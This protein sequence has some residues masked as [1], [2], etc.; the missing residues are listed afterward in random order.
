MSLPFSA[1]TCTASPPP[2]LGH[3]GSVA[4]RIGAGRPAGSQR[5]QASA[6]ME[7]QQWLIHGRGEGST[8]HTCSPYH[9]LDFMENDWVTRHG[10]T[11]HAD[12]RTVSSFSYTKSTLSLLRDHFESIGRVGEWTQYAPTGNPCLSWAVRRWRKGYEKAE[13]KEGIEPTMAFPLTRA[14]LEVLLDRLG[15]SIQRPDG[16]A[17]GRAMRIPLLHRDR[18][19]YAYLYA[20]HQRGGEGSRVRDVDISPAPRDW[21][22]EEVPACVRVCPNGTKVSQ[23]RQAGE[24]RLDDEA[25]PGKYCWKALLMQLKAESAAL[26]VPIP[27]GGPL[28]L[29]SDVSQRGWGKTA[30]TG[31]AALR[32][33]QGSLKEYGLWE[34]ET[35][36]SFR[37]GAI[38]DD[39]TRGVAATDSMAKSL[40]ATKRVYEGYAST[41]RPTKQRRIDEIKGT[42]QD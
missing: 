19:M 10:N 16:A 27:D 6:V 37:S 31:P 38:Q 33:L 1:L 7:L 21:A 30:L 14:K 32:R 28:F 25:Q 22:L 11:P 5:A 20:S 8:E 29:K 42:G 41:C 39:R 13:W 12:G 17:R 3:W 15:D 36:H 18:A 23:R 26:G 4:A 34:G 40:I 35:M 2:G 9:V 24:I